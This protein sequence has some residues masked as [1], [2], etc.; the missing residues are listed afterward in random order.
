MFILKS[1]NKKKEFDKVFSR[2]RS[3]YSK[4]MGIKILENQTEQIRLA[5]MVGTKV[6]K[7]AVE[8]NKFKR[9]I[10]E[11]IRNKKDFFNK[12]YDLVVIAFPAIKDLDTK[13][14]TKDIEKKLKQLKI[15]KN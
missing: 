2:G 11:A 12:G 7:K 3:V 13:N 4:E 6:S 8:R 9:A 1:L 14:I 15:I 10:K 5:I